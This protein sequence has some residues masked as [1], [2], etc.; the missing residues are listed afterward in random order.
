LGTARAEA[1]SG[2]TSQAKQACAKFLDRWKGAD[3]D[4]P[5]LK[6]ATAEAAKFL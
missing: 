4:I 6:Q 5:V 3:A 2:S 1:M